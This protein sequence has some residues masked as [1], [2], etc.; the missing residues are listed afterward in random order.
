MMVR[1]AHG[2]A[3]VAADDDDVLPVGADAPR[4]CRPRRA[5]S[6]ARGTSSQ[7][8]PS[9]FAA[10]DRQVARDAGTDAEET[11]SKSARSFFRDVHACLEDDAFALHLADA[12]SITPLLELGPGC[13]SAKQAADAI[14]AFEHDDVVALAARAPVLPPCPPVPSRPRSRACRCGN[15]EGCDRAALEHMWRAI[16]P[17]SLIATGVSSMLST[18]DALA[19]RRAHASRHLGKLFVDERMRAASS[20]RPR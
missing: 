5:G 12:R 8:T 1:R 2:G 11:A 15:G 19:R 20:M 4:R 17:T 16:A 7:R 6:A 3:G 13:R 9:S 14:V 10:G 18:H